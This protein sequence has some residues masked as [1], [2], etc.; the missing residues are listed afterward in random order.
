VFC[1]LIDRRDLVGREV[2]LAARV[3]GRAW[4]YEP[5]I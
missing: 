5:H 4:S 2:E 3:L 1:V